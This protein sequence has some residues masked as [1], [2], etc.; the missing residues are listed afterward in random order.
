MDLL[1]FLKTIYALEVPSKGIKYVNMQK[2]II[3]K[4][5]LA[6]NT[7]TSSC[8]KEL[9]LENRKEEEYAQNTKI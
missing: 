6:E 7:Y 3:C 8:A 4:P 5:L 1:E 2:L 9:K